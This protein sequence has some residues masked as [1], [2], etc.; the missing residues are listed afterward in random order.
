MIQLENAEIYLR[1]SLA[2][3]RKIEL[4]ESDLIQSLFAA[5]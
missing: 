5:V 4:R 1:L 3:R 2:D